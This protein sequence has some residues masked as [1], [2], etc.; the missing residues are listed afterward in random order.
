M[1]T[2][3]Y[4]EFKI[5]FNLKAAPKNGFACDNVGF[6][7]RPHHTREIWKQCTIIHHE[8]GAFLKC[9]NRGNSKTLASSFRKKWWQNDNRMRFT[10]LSFP[11]TQIN[12]KWPIIVHH[13]NFIGVVWP[14]ANTDKL[15]NTVKTNTVKTA[16]WKSRLKWTEKVAFLKRPVKNYQE[17]KPQINVLIAGSSVCMVIIFLKEY[18]I[19]LGGFYSLN[20]CFFNFAIF[21]QN[22]FISSIKLVF[23]HFFL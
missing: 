16:K 4:R 2:S 18:Y 13:S 11:Q 21:S 5:D 7:P 8:T 9:T 1:N 23:V 6:K 19:M 20:M 10:Y 17:I 3:D 14:G 15:T 22:V 12:P